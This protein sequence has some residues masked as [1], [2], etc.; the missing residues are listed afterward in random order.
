[1]SRGY[2]RR[3]ER[4][5]R[6]I[7]VRFGHRAATYGSVA[8]QISTNGMF[9]ATND[10]VFARDS[11]IV[12]EVKGPHETWLVRGIVRHATKVHPSLAAH[13]RAGMGIELIDVP[14]SCRAYLASL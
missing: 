6:R 9:L 10:H 13:A 2:K 5:Y 8:Q 4:K 12:I 7:F 3:E 14:Q 1:V 11:A